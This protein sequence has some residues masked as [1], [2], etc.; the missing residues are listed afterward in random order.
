MAMR[1]LI[2]FTLLTGAAMMSAQDVTLVPFGSNWK[3]LDNGSNQGTAW[4]A[5]GFNDVGWVS[6]PAELGYGDGG[7]ATVVSYGP[8]S[9]TK[10]I[11]TYF[12]KTISI[13]NVNT[14]AGYALRIKRD[15]GIVLYLNGTE[16]LRQNFNEGAVAYNT[17]AYQSVS[18]PEEPTLVEHILLP[19]QFSNGSNTLAV[20]IHQNSGSSSDLSFDLELKGLDSSPSVFRGPYLQA[21]S[22]TGITVCWYSD[23]P[24]SSRVRYGPSPTDLSSTMTI[25]AS[26]LQHEVGLT[27]LLP[28]TT[29]YYAI[30][31]STQD[32]AG[33]DAT[34]FFKTSPEQGSEQPVRIW[35]LGDP[36]TGTQDQVDVRNSYSSFAA[37]SRKADGCILLGDN[38]YSH[39]RECEYIPSMFRNMYEGLLRNTTWWPSPGNHDYYAGVNGIT[40]T[41]PYYNIFATPK[42]GGSGGVASNTEAYYAFDI[43]NVHFI[44]LDS[45]GVSRAAN[46]P[47][48]LWLQADMAYAKAN[49]KWT[50]AYWHHAPYTRGGENSDSPG[51][52]TDMRTNMLPILE[53]GGVD[54]VLAGHSHTYERSFLI[55]GH[56]GLASTFNAGTMGEDLTSGRIGAPHAYAKPADP[57]AHAGTVYAVCGV[58]GK[59]ETGTLNHPVMY[60]S[61]GSYEGSMILDFRSDSLNARFLNDAGTVIDY[62]DIVKPASRLRLAM[63]VM[64]EGPYDPL[65]GMMHDSLRVAGLVPA[66]EPYTGLFTHVGGGGGETVLASVLAVAGSTAIVDWVFLQLRSKANPSLVVATRSALVRRDG[67]VV[68]VD[69]IS[70][71]GFRVPVGDYSVSV[72]HRNHLGAMTAAPIHLNY[73]IASVDLSLPSTP[74]WG[75]GALRNVSGV[76]ALWTGDVLRDGHVRY[77]GQNNDRDPI[78]Q[79]IGGIVPTQT[80]SGYLPSDLGLDGIVRYVGMS[81]DRDPILSAIGGNVPTLELNEQLP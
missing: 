9:S 74:T 35:V 42:L 36:G 14:Y 69:G 29:Y 23:V 15:D 70:P 77:V 3:Y 63:K 75:T 34:H 72:R 55:D 31:T 13:P 59:K 30:G 66:T 76:M 78:L 24:S 25:P 20:E 67:Q 52:S 57:T 28:N 68:D 40:N 50:V 38:V 37:T 44:S 5:S 54:L 49:A 61:T 4:R 43:G 11:T 12:R 1:Y 45:Y 16:I 79:A 58:S 81:N 62:F 26:V 56:Y 18:D 48:A 80:V 64:L 39:G 73:T 6:G 22:P 19:A 51:E 27:G 21:A 53:Q 46:G 60:M 7:E 10:Y 8:N 65:N 71:V 2:T 41:G 32:L 47:M 17:V 33:G